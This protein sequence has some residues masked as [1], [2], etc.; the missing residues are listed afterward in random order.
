MRVLALLVAFAVSALSLTITS[1]SANDKVDFSKPYTIKWTTVPSDPQNFTITLVNANGR[2]VSKDLTTRA[3]SD[4][5]E[6]RVDR[7][8]DIPVANNYQINFRSTA[9]ENQGILA[10]SHMF[11]VTRVADGPAETQTSTAT[12]TATE[13][14]STPMETNAAGKVVYGA[15]GAVAGVMGL[16]ALAL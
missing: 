10:Q 9:R 5:N 1:P 16:L 8:W 12:A 13:S 3:E 15:P 4:K 2:N 6:Y 11:N 7:V 14:D